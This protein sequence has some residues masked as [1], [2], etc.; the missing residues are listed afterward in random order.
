MLT[1]RTVNASDAGLIARR[2]NLSEERAREIVAESETKRFGGRYS[3]LFAVENGGAAV[4]LFSVYEH[5]ASIVSIGP[6]IFPEYRRRGYAKAAMRE[7]LGMAKEKR[8][9]VVLQQIRTDNEA[10]IRLHES[11]GF[12]KDNTVYKNRHGHDVYIYLKAL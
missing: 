11:L 8:Y 3:E 9:A 7:F 5:A 6:E 1:I 2:W 10:S 4:G 12:E